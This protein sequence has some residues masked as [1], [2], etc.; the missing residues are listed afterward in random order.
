MTT[1]PQVC[2][3]MSIAIMMVITDDILAIDKKILK[4][5][6]VAYREDFMLTLK[7]CKFSIAEINKYVNQI[8]KEIGW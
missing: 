3:A 6:F 4:E 7:E 2:S 1:R 8:H 5:R